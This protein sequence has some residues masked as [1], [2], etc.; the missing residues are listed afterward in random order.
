MTMTRAEINRR[1]AAS[2]REQELAKVKRWQAA[3]P[4]RVRENKRRDR[5]THLEERRA[6]DRIRCARYRAAHPERR[7]EATSRYAS[8]HPAYVKEWKAAHP[9]RVSDSNQKRRAIL[10]GADR[11]PV[12]RR[13]VFDRDNGL[14]HLCGRTVDWTVRHPDPLSK[15][16]DHLIPLAR[17]GKH[18]PT[19]VALAHLRCN[20][21]R[22]TRPIQQEA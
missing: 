13:A 1:Y 5:A 15:S 21:Q 3:H 9:D 4:D 11:T 6:A 19:N 7:L 18:E 10:H 8:E 16:L 20:I 17:G 12:S 22:G 2:H 14:C